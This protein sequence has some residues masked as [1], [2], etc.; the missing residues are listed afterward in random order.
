MTL[1][2]NR[3]IQETSPYLLQHAHNPVNWYPWCDEAFE[4]AKRENKPVLVSIGYSACH[5]CHVME[6]ESFENEDTA[7][8]MNEYF[9]NIK[10]DREERPDVDHLYMDAV[11][12]MTGSGGWPLNVFLTPEAK[13]FYGGTYFPPRR[14]YNRSSWPEIITAIHT[15]FTERKHEIESQAENLTQ[16]LINA[17]P[18][19]L[20]TP[21]NQN[22]KELF[23]K[24]TLST[25]VDRI[26]SA[27]D[28]TWGGF[29]N[30]PKFPQT[31]VIQFLLRHY[32][33]FK[34][35]KA[36]EQALL[37][38]DKM[39]YGGIHDQLGGGFAR[40]STDEKWLAPH[41][42]KML[43]DNAL[44]IS[45]LAE[46][47]Q[48]TKR[49]LYLDTIHTTMAFI[50]NELLDSEGGFYSA[51]DADSEG[52]EGK[53]YTWSKAEIDFILGEDANLFC[54]YFDVEE[55]G[56]WEHTNILWV[57]KTMEQFVSENEID[58]ELFSQKLE[59]NKNLLLAHR[60][61]RIKPQL[62]DKIILSW[63]SLM[64][65]A[66]SKAFAATGKEE[67]KDLAIKNIHFI[68]TNFFH[69]ETNTISHT[70]KNGLAKYPAFLDDYAYLIQ[71]Y[72]HLQEISGDT[73][74]L[75]NAF[76]LLTEVKLNFED[77]NSGLFFYTSH[78]QK[79]II[80]KKVEIY[81]G[82]TPSA[83]SLLALSFHYLGII[84]DNQE[85]KDQA[86]N[87]LLQ[88]N[89]SISRYPISF[90]NWAIFLQVKVM[91]LAEI[92]ITG[93]SVNASLAEILREYYPFKV[94]QSANQQKDIFPLLKNK[95]FN[96]DVEIYLCKDY[97]CSRPVENVKDL[98]NL[99]K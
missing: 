20:G 33:A 72:I 43:Y 32:H 35:E 59:Q 41:F 61:N 73:Q 86:E 37:S 30:A 78:S 28:K 48:L 91:G 6:K 31:G 56:N 80:A 24:E 94:L 76:K 52:V 38:L 15:S 5:W 70:Y 4:I 65:I 67:Y 54:K 25:I 88:I 51:L 58:I 63:N 53:F 82:A 40:Y 13:P 16:H 68:E 12:A 90:A 36:L 18:F 39:I 2:T 49:K 42:E 83:N 79:D 96:S 81:D 1:H 50:Q 8:L 69:L 26:L 75:M 23:S 47:Y 9:I 99:L 93:N 45:V 11:Q 77:E 29:G 27:A 17:N 71:A 7:K 14:A 85:W 64:N 98:K 57:S 21:N 89:S 87:M 46:A 62:D 97:I 10:V 60:N 34:D 55:E 74:Y 84:F 95:N 44:L 19:G 3:L 92:V 22:E 66:C